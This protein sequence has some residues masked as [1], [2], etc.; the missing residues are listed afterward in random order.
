MLAH[1]SLRLKKDC[2]KMEVSLN[3]KQLGLQVSEEHW[4]GDLVQGT[5]PPVNDW[6]HGLKYPPTHSTSEETEAVDS[7]V[8]GTPWVPVCSGQVWKPRTGTSFVPGA[9]RAPDLA[10]RRTLWVGTGTPQ[11]GNQAG[12]RGR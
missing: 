2:P 3:Y 12:D 11:N 9:E 6:G 4:P 5:P 10:P 8:P 1:T 7:M